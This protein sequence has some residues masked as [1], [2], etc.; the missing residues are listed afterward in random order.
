[1]IVDGWLEEQKKKHKQDE[2]NEEKS[3]RFIKSF[4]SE[5]AAEGYTSNIISLSK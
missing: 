5:Q 4:L 1:M 3:W 2:D